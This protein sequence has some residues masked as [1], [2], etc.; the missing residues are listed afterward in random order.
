MCNITDYSH[1]AVHYTPMT[2]LLY[3]WKSVPLDL[4]HPCHSPLNPS[5]FWQPYFC[6]LYLWVCFVFIHWFCFLDSTKLLEDGHT[7][8]AA[9]ATDIA[10]M[11]SINRLAWTLNYSSLQLSSVSVCPS[12]TAPSPLLLSHLEHLPLIFKLHLKLPGLLESPTVAPW[13][14]SSHLIDT[15][16]VQCHAKESWLL[17]A[18]ES[19]Y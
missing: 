8:N 11:A 10:V 16:S 19:L 4:L 18:V 6:S 15:I 17:E 7:F 5:S 13:L 12:P 14:Q 1:L 9:I 3:N 2:Y